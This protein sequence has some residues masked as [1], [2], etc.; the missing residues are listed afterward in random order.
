MDAALAK[1]EDLAKLRHPFYAITKDWAQAE[2]L[3]RI[4]STIG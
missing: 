1:A 2:L 4:R 3:Q